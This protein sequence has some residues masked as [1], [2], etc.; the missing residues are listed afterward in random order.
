MKLRRTVLRRLRGILGRSFV[1]A[2]GLV[3]AL[4]LLELASGIGLSLWNVD[5]HQS[6][7][8]AGANEGKCSIGYLRHPYWSVVLDPRG[9]TCGVKI[10]RHGFMDDDWT[11]SRWVETRKERW[12]VAILGGSVASHVGNLAESQSLETFIRKLWRD[13]LGSRDVR[14]W[15]LAIPSWRLPQQAHLL[16]SEHKHFDAVVH[17]FGYNESGLLGLPIS[18]DY[19]PDFMWAGQSE[20]LELVSPSEVLIIGLNRWLVELRMTFGWAEHSRALRLM[21]HY[22]EQLA[23]RSMHPQLLKDWKQ[24]LAVDPLALSFQAPENRRA[25][26]TVHELLLYGGEVVRDRVLFLDQIA[27]SSGIQ[28]VHF[29]Q[30]IIQDKNLL[31]GNELLTLQRLYPTHYP[32]LREFLKTRLKEDGVVLRDLRDVFEDDPGDFFLDEVHLRIASENGKYLSEGYRKIAQRIAREFAPA[33][34]VG[35]H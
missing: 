19:T 31:S 18:P 34:R 1:A 27:R 15:N 25:A 33:R 32:W 2:L 30:P 10:N 3:L 35:N 28:I 23:M 11:E 29:L 8:I 13:R 21:Q 22:S 12:D 24:A 9:T 6:N 17:L 16:A 20:W 26:Q 5:Q 7:R 4:L 14:V